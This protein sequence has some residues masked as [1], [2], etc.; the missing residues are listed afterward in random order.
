[1]E[2]LGKGEFGRSALVAM[3]IQCSYYKR[4]KH[5]RVMKGVASGITHGESVTLVAVKLLKGQDIQNTMRCILL[6]LT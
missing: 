6:L 5:C 2:E 4:I 3:Y 1:M